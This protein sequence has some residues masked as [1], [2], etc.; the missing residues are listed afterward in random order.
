MVKHR[1]TDMSEQT[2]HREPLAPDEPDERATA[3]D[4]VEGHVWLRPGSQAASP[5]SD[6]DDDVEG[7]VWLRPGSQAA[8]PGSD[9][10]DDVEGHALFRST[11]S[12]GE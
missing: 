4:D 11:A 12:R 5:G 8:S 6:E 1:E 7:H 9:E 2:S 10:D 3:D